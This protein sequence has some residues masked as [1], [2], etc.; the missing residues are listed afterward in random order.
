[1]SIRFLRRCLSLLAPVASALA[2]AC[3]T[4]PSERSTGG[5]VEVGIVAIND[6]HGNL[7]PPHLSVPLGRP[8]SSVEVPAGGAAYLAGAIAAT[9]QGQA[10]SIVVA[11]GDMVGASPLTSSLFADE[12][13]IL[14]MNAA[15]LELS[16]VGNHEFDA[17]Q[18]ELMRLAH[19]GCAQFTRKVPC[20]LDPDFP[21]ARFGFLAANVLG[22]NGETLFPGTALKRFGT[23]ARAVTIGFIGE[24]LHGAPDVI[25]AAN[26]RGLRFAEEA[27]VANAAAA[28]LRA[29]GAD[30]V[31]L[32]IHQGLRTAPDYAGDGCAGLSGSLLPVLAQLDPVIDVVVSGHSHARYVCDYRQIDPARPFLVTSAESYGTLLTDIR[33]RIDPAAHR[34][35]SRTARNVI[36]QG[37]GFRGPDGLVPLTDAAPRFPADPAVAA[38]VARYASAAAPLLNRVVGTMTAPALHADQADREAPLNGLIADAQAAAT[39]ADLALMNS[40]GVRGDLVPEAGGRVTFGG[41]YATQPFGNTLVVKRLTGRQLL[42]LLEQ[43]M[44]EGRTR[45]NLLAPSAALR[46]TLDRAAPAGR[47]VRDVTV[48]GRPLSPDGQYRVAANSFLAAGGDGFSVLGTAAADGTGTIVDVDAL[49]AYLRAHPRLV[50]PAADRITLVG[51]AAPR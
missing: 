31:V 32:L 36:V 49:E 37:E 1:M 7:E 4:V 34:V 30:A 50:P 12:P 16:A 18:P 28:R 13:A 25:A 2:S 20:R 48:A 45:P 40:G 46:F 10:N 3:A 15:G 51:V 29:Q 35:V 9:R 14:A 44:P 8:G 5:P 23:G 24:T 11:A 22:P 19:G 26:I 41:L 38:L 6:F 42:A 47:R 17:G 43:Q 21:G 33:L 27:S 39:G